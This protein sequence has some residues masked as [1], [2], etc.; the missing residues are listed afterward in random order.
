[1]TMKQLLPLLML[2][3]FFSSGSR[4]Q[5]PKNTFAI[6]EHD[7][8][9]NGKPI[10][11][12][13]GE[14]H[15]ARIPR[16]YWRDRLHMAR[17]MGLNTVAT[18][19]FWNYH[20]PE[21]GVYNFSGNADVAEFVRIA[22]E[23]GLWVIIRPSPYACA[24]WEFGG[25][26]WWLQKEKGLKVRSRDP[27]FLAMSRNYFAALGKQ[28]APLQ[29]TRGGPVI[30]VQLENEYGSYDKDK[31]YLAI[32]R[33]IIRD[34]G[35]DVALYTCDGPSQMP[36][37]YLPGVFPSVNGLDNVPE[38]KSLINKFNN[39]HGPYFIAEWY[40]AWFDSWGLRHHLVPWQE[41]AGIFDTVLAAGF[42][43]NIYMAHGGTTREFMNGANM[44]RRTPYSPQTSSYDYDAPIDEAGNATP[45]FM[46][47][48]D[49]IL[50]N[51][52]PGTTIP[53]VP[54]KKP[55][56]A[57]PAF[58]LTQAAALFSNLPEP[59]FSE[60][61]LTFEDLNQGYGYVL[62]RT[63]VSGPL[64]G[65]MHIRH[66]RDYGLVY[67]D[68]KRIAIL[69]R[70]FGQEK[71]AVEI[72]EGE[73][74]L[75]ILTE[76]LGRINYG[77][78]LN[79]NLK[80]IT[81]SVL[82]NGTELANWNMYGF[83]MSVPPVYPSE[84][85]LKGDGPVVRT[86]TFTVQNTADTWLD[87]RG[88]GKGCVWINGHH[89]GRYWNVGPTQTVYVPAPWL[90]SGENQVVVFELQEGAMT[91]LSLIDHP[92]LDMLNS[93]KTCR[94]SLS[95]GKKVKVSN[96]WSSRYAAGGD[97]ALVDDLRGSL[98]FRD[99][100]WQGYE[101]TD[102][103]AVVDL[104]SAMDVRELGLG[105]LQTAASWVFLPSVVEFY[106]SEDGNRFTKTGEVRNSE[107]ALRED[108]FMK[109]FILER[110]VKGVRYV[111]VVAR[112]IGTCPQGHPGS[113]KKAWLCAEERSVR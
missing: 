74:T 86:G 78:Y 87:M 69:D 49:V 21:K 89:L 42:S 60:R 75:D 54:A 94:P 56:M 81:G 40:P 68:G 105:C 98:N 9:L 63:T 102:L 111:K 7:F 1:M 16:E 2:L 4:A 3:L 106:T 39:N 93:P 41:V 25:Y 95:T 14:M 96:A 65:E 76:N 101:G 72:P 52:A 84:K 45:K 66:L 59:V 113:G 51:S 44:D 104:G 36:D 97:T 30:M 55:V 6:G 29:I 57:V 31:E 85:E 22:Q 112:N 108:A 33:Q 80:G 82:I 70:R 19:V 99:E 109:E 32:N 35:F 47:F 53:D 23:E 64:T 43:I 62:Y 48:R 77:P 15:F 73:H 91:R 10:R 34:S 110:E 88:W 79:D 27:E 17:A 20:E 67:M 83:P 58:S 24:E 12:I 90:K 92:I 71:V 26:P 37:G 107:P 46:A 38:V 11:L 100:S 28:L 13:S 103:E 50:K 18:Y 8:L 61:P 5:E